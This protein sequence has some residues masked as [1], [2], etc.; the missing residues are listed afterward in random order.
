MNTPHWKNLEKASCHSETLLQL[1]L[2]VIPSQEIG[3]VLAHIFEKNGIVKSDL[4]EKEWTFRA[5][6]KF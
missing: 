4:I 1:G 5:E 2:D 3:L 6:L